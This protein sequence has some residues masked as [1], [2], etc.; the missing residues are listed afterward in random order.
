MSRR[1]KREP[2]QELQQP[3]GGGHT[4]NPSTRRLRQADLCEFKTGLVYR[5]S[6]HTARV[7]QR[8]IASRKQS[9]N[10]KILPRRNTTASISWKRKEGCSSLLHP[11]F[12][13]CLLHTEDS[14]ANTLILHLEPSVDLHS[15]KS[16]G[17]VELQHPQVTNTAPQKQSEKAEPRESAT[18][19]PL[20]PTRC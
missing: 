2:S 6:S 19:A 14:N 4:F 20:E 5:V 12:C 15:F 8:S 16:H 13:P 7:T 9:K 18:W 17:V 10:N 11:H 3:G 1:Q